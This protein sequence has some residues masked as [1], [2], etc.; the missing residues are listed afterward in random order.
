VPD[1]PGS[2]VALLER[3]RRGGDLLAPLLG[4]P[5]VERGDV[6]GLLEAMSPKQREAYE[7]AQAAAAAEAEVEEAGEIDDDEPP[8]L[9]D[10]K[11]YLA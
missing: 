2:A 3:D 6:P 10:A 1:R 8:D 7:A 9:T 11:V 4:E 5:L